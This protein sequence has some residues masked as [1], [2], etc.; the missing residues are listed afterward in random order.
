MAL[1]LDLPQLYQRPSA[2]DLLSTLG[3]LTSKPS[4]WDA[5]PRSSSLQSPN[6]VPVRRKRKIKNEGV[7]GYLT[8]IISSPLAWIPDD[9]E[10]EQVWEA[11]SQRLSERSGRTATGAITRTFDV[12]LSA[13]VEGAVDGIKT[14]MQAGVDKVLK[15]VIHEP[16]LTSDNLGLK[17]WASAFL[18]AKRLRL[19]RSTLP[20][21][22]PDASILEL[23]AGT[24][25]VGLAAA[26]VFQRQVYLTDLPEIVPNLEKNVHAN[27]ASIQAY[28]GSAEAAVLDWS[29]PSA[30]EPTAT[31]QS[32]PLVLAAD[33]VYSPKQPR[34]LASAIQH[35]ISLDANARLLTETPV[36]EG[37]SEE[38]AELRERLRALGL[39]VLMEGEDVGVDD[40][41]NADDSDDENEEN[42]V[43]CRWAI[44]GWM[45]KDQA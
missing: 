34:L 41:G 31:P 43:R 5:S 32:F 27:V 28:D 8:K 26:A 39:E 24:G 37:Y 17:T 4:S 23:G 12:Q 30:F 38:R 35:H 29:E 45:A 16:T 2:R 3:D 25:L 22:E 9:M 40:W 36:R 1:V 33:S 21:L 7:P 42:E 11:A 6:R 13:N 15:L 19:F 18:L 20:L 14:S 44:W 10:K